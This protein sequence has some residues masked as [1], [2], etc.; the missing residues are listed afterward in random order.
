MRQ[1]RVGVCRPPGADGCVCTARARGWMGGG[2]E[3]QAVGG[4]NGRL[5]VT[6]QP[7]QAAR[8]SPFRC[9]AIH[10]APAHQ[11]AT[12]PHLVVLH[13]GVALEQ[14]VKLAEGAVEEVA[15]G[16]VVGQH[17]PAHAV[18]RLDKGGLA[19]QRHLQAAA[20][21]AGWRLGWEGRGCATP[22]RGP[23]PSLLPSANTA[24]FPPAPSGNPLPATTTHTH[25]HTDT[26]KPTRL[27]GC[28]PPV[29]EV[30]QLALPDA[31]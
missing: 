24:P 29:D 25:T 31:H 12:C 15:D 22:C 2:V 21:G 11:P 19:G 23:A 5:G 30:C 3:A 6:R 27:N 13:K 14:L 8:Q 20:A 26:H 1:A 16:G 7:L 10:K 17:Q 4:Y 28:G 9:P 18:S